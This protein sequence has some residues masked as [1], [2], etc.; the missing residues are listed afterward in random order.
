MPA[1]SACSNR[2]GLVGGSSAYPVTSAPSASNHSESQL[3]LKPVCP[4]RNTWRPFQNVRLSMS[5]SSVKGQHHL[6]RIPPAGAGCIAG[7]SGPRA[8]RGHRAFCSRQSVSTNPLAG[9]STS[10][11]ETTSSFA[12]SRR[13]MQ[14]SERPIGRAVL[15][16]SDS[17][18]VDETIRAEPADSIEPLAGFQITLGNRHHFADRARDGSDRRITMDDRSTDGRGDLDVRQMKRCVE[19][20]ER[21]VAELVVCELSLL[22]RASPRER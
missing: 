15:S 20:V 16:P 19:D 8:S 1:T 12:T 5:G 9:V 7:D 18:V 6:H 21:A 11:N 14:P 22:E 3:P 13:K 2:L 4:V 10:S 17:G